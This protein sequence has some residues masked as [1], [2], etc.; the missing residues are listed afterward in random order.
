MRLG[1]PPLSTLAARPPTAEQIAAARAKGKEVVDE[2]NGLSSHLDEPAARARIR[3]LAREN[4]GAFGDLG[5]LAELKARLNP[6]ET[7]A[8]FDSE[9]ALV[10]W[11]QDYVRSRW[12]RNPLY[13]KAKYQDRLTTRPAR[14]RRWRRSPRPPRRRKRSRRRR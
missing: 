1:Q 10:W 11:K 5:V 13:F 3:E 14:I 9:L 7:Q 2:I 4:L 6:A 12:Q 8:A